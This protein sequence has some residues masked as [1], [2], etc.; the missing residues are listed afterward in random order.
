MLKTA[1]EPATSRQS[2]DHRSQFATSSKTP[3]GDTRRTRNGKAAYGYA[4]MNTPLSTS[5]RWAAN[6]DAPRLKAHH[7]DFLSYLWTSGGAMRVVDEY[8]VEVEVDPRYGNGRDEYAAQI[9]VDPSTVSR[10]ARDL[11]AH[12]LIDTRKTRLVERNPAGQGRTVWIVRLPRNAVEHREAVG[13]ARC[14]DESNRRVQ[15]REARRSGATLAPRRKDDRELR[16]DAIAHTMQ[17]PPDDPTDIA[18]M[19]GATRIAEMQGAIDI[20]EMQGAT[21]IAKLQCAVSQEEQQ[22]KTTHPRTAVATRQ[23]TGDDAL[24]FRVLTE[25]IAISASVAADLVGQLGGVVCCAFGHCHLDGNPSGGA[26]AFVYKARQ[27]DPR[28][29]EY[30]RHGRRI[31]PTLTGDLVVD[32][33]D[34]SNPPTRRQTSDDRRRLA[35]GGRLRTE[36]RV[37]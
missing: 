27:G 29:F 25:R 21:H 23:F 20:A 4:I 9:G 34:G 35:N 3:V 15:V 5:C 26:G 33:N 31:R 17:E 18:E 2:I 37:G 14:A 36:A 8:S 7:R 1:T 6:P 30:N 11:K 16:N 24:A 19:Q 12:G 10:W 28:A 32:S 22:I 13:S